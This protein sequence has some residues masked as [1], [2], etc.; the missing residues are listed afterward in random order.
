[1]ILVKHYL[2]LSTWTQLNSF[3]GDGLKLLHWGKMHL[4]IVVD[5]LGTTVRYFHE[6]S[7][8]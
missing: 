2:L 8:H 7:L 4:G 6:Q 1:M 5:C 3:Q